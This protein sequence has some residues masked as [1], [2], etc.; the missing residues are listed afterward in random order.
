M[1]RKRRTPSD[2]V[3]IGD[4]AS[5]C[6]IG[7]HEKRVNGDSIVLTLIKPYSTDDQIRHSISIQITRCSDEVAKTVAVAQ[8]RTTVQRICDLCCTLRGAV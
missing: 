2:G 7:I 8:W 6:A 5:D 1:V 4:I 3:L